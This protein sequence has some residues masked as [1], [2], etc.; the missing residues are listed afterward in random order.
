MPRSHHTYTCPADDELNRAGVRREE[1]YKC[2]DSGFPR[3]NKCFTSIKSSLTPAA[4]ACSL[5]RS[6]PFAP[7]FPTHLRLLLTTANVFSQGSKIYKSIER[8]SV[9][10]KFSKGL[11]RDFKMINLPDSYL[12]YL[13]TCP[14]PRGQ[15]S[16][17]YCFPGCWRHLLWLR[18]SHKCQCR[19]GGEEVAGER[20]SVDAIGE[21]D[22]GERASERA[23]HVANYSLYGIRYGQ[24]VRAHRAMQRAQ[25][26]RERRC[27]TKKLR[28]IIETRCS[29]LL[30]NLA[31]CI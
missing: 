16:R 13:R 21:E 31:S 17:W 1:G 2:R 19:I 24:T 11:F 15:A 6:L 14:Y 9:H 4:Q 26:G 27:E 28:N 25:L 20:A 8:S 30:S 10:I 3:S 29:Y 23:K 7:P 12:D 18:V 22:R 5:S